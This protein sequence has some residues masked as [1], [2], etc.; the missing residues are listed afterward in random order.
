LFRA[1][2]A[3]TDLFDEKSIEEFLIKQSSTFPEYCKSKGL[4]IK[5]GYMY[6]FKNIGQSGARLHDDRRKKITGI[7]NNNLYFL[8]I[9]KFLNRHEL[10]HTLIEIGKTFQ[11][12]L[13]FSNYDE[14][15]SAFLQSNTILKTMKNV[16]KYLSGDISVEL[17]VLQ[18]AYVDAQIN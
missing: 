5:D 13:D 10:K 6:A 8:P 1:G 2:D 15:Y 3:G 17:D 11:I 12:K 16:E 14:S 18:Q 9:S 4:S 7:K